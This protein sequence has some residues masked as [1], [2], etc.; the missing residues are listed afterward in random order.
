[1]HEQ[2]VIPGLDHSLV[3]K[4]GGLFMWKQTPGFVNPKPRENARKATN[5]YW[6]NPE[7]LK[8]QKSL[9]GDNNQGKDVQ[10]TAKK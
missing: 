4:E 10:S 9:F 5:K 3:K 1:M 8:R 7:Q 2:L 6:T